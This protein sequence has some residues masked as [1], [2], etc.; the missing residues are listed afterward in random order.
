[1]SIAILTSFDLDFPDGN[2]HAFTQITEYVNTHLLNSKNPQQSSAR[3]QANTA[4]TITS[5][6]YAAM[7]TEL[8]E[9]ER[10]CSEITV[11]QKKNKNKN[12]KQEQ[13]NATNKTPRALGGGRSDPTRTSDESTEGLN[14]CYNHGRQHSHDSPECKSMTSDKQKYNDAMRRARG[15]NHL[16]GGSTK[17]NG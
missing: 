5:G 9:L 2:A 13:Q 15:P 14:Y 17:V 16:P 10:K 3:L 12:I 4:N 7:K 1:M 11:T 6:A 8:Q